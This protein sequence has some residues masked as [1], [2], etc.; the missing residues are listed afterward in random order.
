MCSVGITNMALGQPQSEWTCYVNATLL[1]QRA[2]K[3]FKHWKSLKKTQSCLADTAEQLGLHKDQ[4][5]KCVRNSRNGTRHT[6][7]HPSLHADLEHWC[8]FKK[9]EGKS[10]YVYTVTSPLLNAVKI[11]C[12][13]GSV[14]DLRKRY[15]TP[16]GPDLKVKVVHVLNCFAIEAQVHSMFKQHCLGGELFD[17]THQAAY[18]RTL[19]QLDIED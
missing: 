3:E 17:K 7:L 13:K 12:W 16:Y 14:N 19:S 8:K 18:D 6:W 2:G 11:G 5:L 15:V 10:G 1:C 9:D 4:M